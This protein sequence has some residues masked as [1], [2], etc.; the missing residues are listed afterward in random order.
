MVLGLPRELRQYIWEL[1]APAY[2]TGRVT[3]EQ[4]LPAVSVIKGQE[5]EKLAACIK[6]ALGL[7][8]GGGVMVDGQESVVGMLPEVFVSEG[9]RAV[10]AVADGLMKGGRYKGRKERHHKSKIRSAGFILHSS[11]YPAAQQQLDR[12]RND[13]QTTGRRR[14]R[15]LRGYAERPTTWNLFLIE[16]M[17]QKSF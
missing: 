17:L 5:Q 8:G 13:E 16:C 12:D 6:Y 10:T 1:A 2:L 11:Q 3:A 14:L 4:A 15:R 7:E 9:C